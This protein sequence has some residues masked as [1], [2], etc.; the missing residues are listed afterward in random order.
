ME[1]TI[2]MKLEVNSGLTDGTDTS[3][4]HSIYIVKVS[5]AVNVTV[6][7]LVTFWLLAFG[8]WR[9]LQLKTGII[10]LLT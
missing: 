10:G 5:Y 4:P 3:T 1:A 7:C 6:Q 2:R 9:V 8:M